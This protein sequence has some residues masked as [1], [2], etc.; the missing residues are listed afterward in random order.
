MLVHM[1]RAEIEAQIR[2]LPAA[3]RAALMDELLQNLPEPLRA[4]LVT[5][6][7]TRRSPEELAALR[8]RFESEVAEGFASGE[9]REWS[10]AD[11]QRLESGDYRYPARGDSWATP[12][13]WRSPRLGDDR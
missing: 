4:D 12:P 6:L 9:S 7:V 11:W 13:G 2:T 1:T 5:R 3:E 10:D 8:D